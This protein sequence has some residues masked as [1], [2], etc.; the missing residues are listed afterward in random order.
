MT[1]RG[2]GFMV[3]EFFDDFNGSSLDSSRWKVEGGSYSLSDSKISLCA[4]PQLSL[5]S[6]GT[7]DELLQ[8]PDFVF[9]VRLV[10]NFSDVVFDIGFENIYYHYE[11]KNCGLC[12]GDKF[13]SL[14]SYDIQEDSLRGTISFYIFR[15]SGMVCLR[16]SLCKNV[17][18]WNVQSFDLGSIYLGVFGGE[19]VVDYLFLHG[20]YSDLDVKIL[21]YQYQKFD[22]LY[23]EW[24]DSPGWGEVA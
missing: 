9:V 18:V 1:A 15:T 16:D 11:S 22:S 5:K 6:V 14:E 7:V 3:F 17:R 12:V 2:S 13:V 10:S 4:S 19:V 24:A 21:K 8:Y 23:F 20:L